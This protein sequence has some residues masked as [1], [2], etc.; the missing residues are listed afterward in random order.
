MTHI[1][2]L[3]Y[4]LSGISGI[5]SAIY[6]IMKYGNNS[7][8][9]KGYIGVHLSYT[10]LMLSALIVLYLKV[11]VIKSTFVSSVFIAV[12]I[13]GQGILARSISRLSFIVD[14]KGITKSTKILWSVI[15]LLFVVIAMLQLI[16]WQTTFSFYPIII[17]VPSFILISI[18]FAHRNSKSEE[19]KSSNEN[20]LWYFF[21]LFTLAIIAL[22]MSLKYYFG[23]LGDYTVNIPIIFICWNLL[24]MSQIKAK[25]KRPQNNTIILDEYISKW[26][27]TTREVEISTAILRGHSNKEIA[28]DLKISTSTVKNHIYNIYK[29]TEVNSRVDLVNLL[30]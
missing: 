10:F 24:N 17:A 6:L 25:I 3:L 15:P 29:K 26:N 9:M 16:L 19:N 18:W 22:E 23:F 28:F 2:L 12:I 11:N 30:N 14:K 1:I 21:L 20:R 8:F 5:V 13:L 27:L 7:D 4:L